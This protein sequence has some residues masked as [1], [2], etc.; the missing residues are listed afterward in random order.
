[1]S[2]DPYYKWLGI[3]PDEQPPHHYR[4]LAIKL[5]EADADVIESAADQRMAHLRD[6][7][8][9]KN[10]AL[11]QKLLNEISTAKVELL[12]PEKKKVYDQTLRKKQGVPLLPKANPPL[13]KAI[14]LPSAV[15]TAGLEFSV[16]SQAK[17]STPRR[18]VLLLIAGGGIITA[19]LAVTAV[20]LL[21]S[22]G[23]NEIP[24][25]S[26]NVDSTHR[27]EAK[28][29]TPLVASLPAPANQNKAILSNPPQKA[30][31]NHPP[32]RPEK[33]I[34]S[35]PVVTPAPDTNKGQA[36]PARSVGT[37]ANSDVQ[38]SGSAEIKDPPPSEPAKSDTPQ[39][40][41]TNRTQ[42][43][44]GV[45]D[46]S[47]VPTQAAREGA[48]KTVNELFG[49]DLNSAKSPQQKSQFAERMLKEGLA[50]K[51]DP[52]GKYALLDMA[53]RVSEQSGDLDL[54][55]RSCDRLAESYDV[56]DYSL[57]EK[58]LEAFSK[59]AKKPAEW[60][61]L[62]E[63]GLLLIDSAVAANDFPAAQRIGNLSLE[64]ARKSRLKELISQASSRAKQ[65]GT[66]ASAYAAAQSALE[67]IKIDSKDAKSQQLVG[68]F[69][70]FIKEDWDQ[71]LPHLAVGA[72]EVLAKMAA[73]EKEGPLKPET[74]SEL[75]DSWYA[76]SKDANTAFREP[77]QRRAL[78]WYQLALPNLSG[79]TKV[80][81]EKLVADLSPVVQ[82]SAV[83][84]KPAKA[85]GPKKAG[86]W[87]AIAGAWKITYAGN[88]AVRNYE[89][90][91]NGNVSFDDGTGKIWKTTLFKQGMDIIFDIKDGKLERFRLDGEIL[92]V[93]HFD[94]A[95]S[96]PDSP[97]YIG[98]G[99]RQ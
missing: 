36:S 38:P 40:E 85:S 82:K 43:A 11:S 89:I 22:Y 88:G 54:C 64:Y 62:C 10:A 51:D 48:R 99:E 49:A 63:E 61:R 79:L 67:K 70:C 78:Y 74:W 29:P 55:L 92:L 50:T 37:S 44:I 7:Q 28:Q 45:P 35:P 84:S 5:F 42:P 95:S 94:Q 20:V 25:N 4:L 58:S 56:T 31:K 47:P 73:Q 75:G 39:Q 12:N 98:R 46:R 57:K 2:F 96:F 19:V 15:G 6:A 14:P 93:E 23:S 72:D 30:E 68:E 26:S 21:L 90:D 27:S 69:L 65:I 1:M 71:G 34:E 59:Q 32:V 33:P 66:I 3:P 87:Q 24:P 81:V 16:Q 91:P 41:N 17:K 77:M 8:G 9:G 53:R 97:K 76:R 60:Q 86:E 13:P 83:A 52:A 80:K 18:P